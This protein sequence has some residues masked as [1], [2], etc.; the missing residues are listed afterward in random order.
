MRDVH[1]KNKIIG[2]GH[3]TF[4]IIETA[5]GHDGSVEKA[6]KIIDY[7]TKAKADAINFHITSMKDYMVPHYTAGAGKSSSTSNTKPLF[8]YLEQINLTHKDWE[9]LIPYAKSKGLLVSALCNDVPSEEFVSKLEPD[10]YS[11]HPSCIAEEELIKKVAKNHKPVI[12]NV[13]GCSIG[14]IDQ[15][16][17]WIKEMKNFDVCLLYGIQT[18]PTAIE[19]AKIGYIKTLQNIFGIPSGMADHT[20]GGS[21][22]ALVVPIAGIVAGANLIEKHVTHDRSL[23]GEDY[24]AA[25]DEKDIIK[26]VDWIRKIEDGLRNPHVAQMSKDELLYRSVSMKKIVAAKDISKGEKITH[27]KLASKRSDEGL[28]LDKK[29]QI[30]GRTASIDIKKDEGISL[31]KVN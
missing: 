15:A 22:L 2:Q 1:V 27:D 31:E 11:L 13:G 23:K 24:E 28:E 17:S 29:Y 26:L 20:D 3:P 8:E 14:E 6:K 19:N 10:M 16:I 21:E 18:Y 4:I 9:V 25:L 7:A 5:W 30:I 12:L